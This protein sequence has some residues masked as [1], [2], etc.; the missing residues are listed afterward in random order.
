MRAEH[1][2]YIFVA[3][4]WLWMVFET[5]V[6]FLDASGHLSSN[7]LVIKRL[8]RFIKKHTLR[9]LFYYKRSDLNES[10]CKNKRK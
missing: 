10:R 4:M 8:F 7:D 3:L 1:L 6:I 2:Q 5:V 9:F